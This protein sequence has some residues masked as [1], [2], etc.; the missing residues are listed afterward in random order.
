M[1]KESVIKPKSKCK[2]AVFLACAAVVL[3]GLAVICVVYRPANKVIPGPVYNK[4]D[5][6]K[7]KARVRRPAATAIPKETA[8]LSYKVLLRTEGYFACREINLDLS[9]SKSPGK[10]ELWLDSGLAGMQSQ[11]GKEDAFEE[12]KDSFNKAKIVYSSNEG[13][14]IDVLLAKS[15]FVYVKEIREAYPDGKSLFYTDCEN[16]AGWG[17]SAGMT[18]EYFTVDSKITTLD[19]YTI[20]SP[21]NGVKTVPARSGKGMDI[22]WLSCAP[23]GKN[24][25]D[26][27]SVFE[28]TYVRYYF[29]EGK[30]N[31]TGKKTNGFWKSDQGF[32]DTSLFP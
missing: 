21:D 25:K 9:N 18:E 14:Q 10:L 4:P 11:D 17:S 26:G 31:K 27:N 28:L 8:V 19:I 2:K 6:I 1:E 12:N 30:W 7:P 5:L 16:G 24:D 13:R 15:P 3:L 23:G 32:P 29:D 20:D 22:L